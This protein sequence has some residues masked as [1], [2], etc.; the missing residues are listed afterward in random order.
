[1]LTTADE[2]TVSTTVQIEIRPVKKG[3]AKEDKKKKKSEQKI[4]LR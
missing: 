2:P 3:G 1:M 4:A